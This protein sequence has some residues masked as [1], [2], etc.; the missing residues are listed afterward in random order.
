MTVTTQIQGKIAHIPVPEIVTTTVI[1]TVSA[2]VTEIETSE[3]TITTGG[4][5]TCTGMI[6]TIEGIEMA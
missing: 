6:T 5:G 1:V 4:L 3:R 2:T